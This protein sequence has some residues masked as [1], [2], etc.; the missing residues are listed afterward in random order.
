MTTSKLEARYRRLGVDVRRFAFG[1]DG[2]PV[3]ETF[4]CRGC[5]C[6]FSPHAEKLRGRWRCPGGCN[7][8]IGRFGPNVS[9]VYPGDL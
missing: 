8:G 1:A 4:S 5:G 9:I 6:V 3:P 2:V 7:K